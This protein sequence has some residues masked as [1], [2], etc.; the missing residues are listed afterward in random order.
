[1]TKSVKITI[2]SRIKYI[3]DGECLTAER[4]LALAPITVQKGTFYIVSSCKGTIFRGV[5]SI[6]ACEG[7]HI[8]IT[9]VP[10]AD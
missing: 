9:E 10:N 1:V 2:N 6:S 8:T 4:I 7:L 3:P 5:G